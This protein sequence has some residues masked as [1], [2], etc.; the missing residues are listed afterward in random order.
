MKQNGAPIIVHF[1]QDFTYGKAQLGGFGRITNLLDTNYHH[2]VFTVSMS[3]RLEGKTFETSSGVQVVQAPYSLNSGKFLKRGK[4][5]AETISYF[6]GYLTQNS[7]T[8]SLFFGHSQLENYEVLNGIKKRLD[9]TTPVIWEF[10]AIWGALNVKGLKNRFVL[11]F[12]LRRRE[13]RI[14]KEANALVFQTSSCVE[15]INKLYGSPNG[16]IRVVT[17]AVSDVISQ[18]ATN[19]NRPSPRR[20]VLVN[21]L[22]DSM[23][24]LGIIVELLKNHWI[25][26]NGSYEFHFYGK[27]QWE[28]EVRTCARNPGIYFHGTVSREE[29]QRIYGQFDFHL[30]PRLPSLEAQL[31]IPSKLLESMS[32]GVVPIVSDV[33]AMTDLVTERVG[34]VARSGSVQDRVEV[35][36]RASKISEG[37]WHELSM[38]SR[39]LIKSSFTV[40][41]NHEI[42]AELYNKLLSR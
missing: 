18:S 25:Q 31:F 1:S 28:E 8:P 13:R 6:S 11:L 21:G 40:Q 12:F 33:A 32:A 4:T 14:V 38:A 35:L 41:R 30:I 17:N 42:L 22:F 23:N 36:L 15:Y 34:F 16:L 19:N 26:L 7:I 20:R 37:D 27:G 29:M 3:D 2:I 24:G 5:I 10:N 9:L 39:S